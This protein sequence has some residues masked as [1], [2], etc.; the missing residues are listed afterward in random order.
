MA[1][2]WR[3]VGLG[4]TL[5]LAGLMGMPPTVKSQDASQDTAKRRV[6][7]K[8]VPEYPSLARQMNVTG[9]V[10]VEAL[11]TADGRVTSTKVIG[12][13]PLLVNAVLDALKKWKF[14]AA[15]KDTTEVLEFDF[16]NLTN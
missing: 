4:T 3:V 7:T 16:R 1:L 11:I 15:P 13:S 14:E 9:K 5:I 2:K 6:R 10:K 8:V 12:G